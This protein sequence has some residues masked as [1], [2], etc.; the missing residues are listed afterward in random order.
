MRL[1]AYAVKANPIARVITE[2]MSLGGGARPGGLL[3]RSSF[4]VCRSRM[5]LD[6]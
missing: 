3:Q 1:Q 4:M 6:C 5:R 2:L